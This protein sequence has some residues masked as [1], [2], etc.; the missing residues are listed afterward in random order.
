MKSF[1]QLLRR[2]RGKLPL[3]EL[4][5]RARVPFGILER[6]AAGKQVPEEAQARQI[7]RMGLELT[8]EDV[9][10][11]LLGLRLYDLG[12]RDNGVRELVTDEI[13]GRLPLPIR[14]RLFRLAGEYESRKA[15]E[16]GRAPEDGKPKR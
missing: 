7:L 3:Q 9:E 5:R 4:A 13:L 14:A 1:A 16:D 11:T 12:L 2:M 6:I 15:P 8:P 10:R